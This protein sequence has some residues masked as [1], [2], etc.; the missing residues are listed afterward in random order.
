MVANGEA[1]T[2]LGQVLVD[3]GSVALWLQTIGAIVILWIFFQVVILYFHNKRMKEVYK[4]KED[5]RR[6]ERKIDKIMRK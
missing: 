4:I 1:E 6:I 5:M 3:L 2:V